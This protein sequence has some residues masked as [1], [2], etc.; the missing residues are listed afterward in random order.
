MLR[1]SNHGLLR[2]ECHSYYAMASRTLPNRPFKC[3]KY[4]VPSFTSVDS[5]L[6]QNQNLLVWIEIQVLL[7]SPCN[8]C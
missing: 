6:L 2:G 8:S 4:V 5:L 7:S 3:I 1:E